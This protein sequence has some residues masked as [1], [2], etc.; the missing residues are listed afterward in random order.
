MISNLSETILFF[1]GTMFRNHAISTHGTQMWLQKFLLGLLILK[2]CI[3]RMPTVFLTNGTGYKCA[4]SIDNKFLSGIYTTKGR[5][6]ALNELLHES[7]KYVK[8]GDYVLA[9]DWYSA[10]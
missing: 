2:A 1:T 6:Q 7:S 3:T 10:L 9:Y 8:K 4:Y 5:S